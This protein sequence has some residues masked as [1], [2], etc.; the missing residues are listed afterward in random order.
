MQVILHIGA[1]CTDEDRIVT[2]L[3]R[4]DDLLAEH[5]SMAPSPT[6]YRNFLRETLFAMS[7][8]SGRRVS[9]DEVLRELLGDKTTDRLILSN[10]NFVCQPPRIFDGGEFYRLAS[11]RLADLSQLFEGDELELYLSIR[12]PA[13]FLS[14]V[15][16]KIEGKTFDAFLNGVDPLSIQWSDM[17]YRIRES[18]PNL[19]ITT[20]CNEDLPLLWG[21]LVRDIAGLPYGVRMKGSFAIIR[22]IMSQEGMLRFRNY[23]AKHPPKN[24][25]HM[26]RVI[27]AFLD[28]YAMDDA[29]EEEITT[30]G[31]SEALLVQMTEAYEEDLYE[32]ERIPG[33]NFLTP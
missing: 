27:A 18:A 28:K 19:P 2:T 23:L 4:N 11:K 1:H 10:Q 24:E 15:Y 9:R 21:Y 6:V 3:M 30:P 7:K 32:I 33:V 31:L 20:W 22:E 16:G 25:V 14:D 26:R 12:N 13:T 5:G 17:I 8:A 29:I